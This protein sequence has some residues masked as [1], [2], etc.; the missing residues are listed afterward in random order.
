[1]NAVMLK[2]KK[3]KNTTHVNKNGK[4]SAEVRIGIG[5][6]DSFLKEVLLN[7]PVMLIFFI[8]YSKLKKV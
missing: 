4:V 5:R 2:K 7:I 3:G 6:K 8:K 1:M